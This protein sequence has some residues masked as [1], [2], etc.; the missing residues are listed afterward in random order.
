V[1]INGVGV[2]KAALF[3]VPSYHRPRGRRRREP[4]ASAGRLES[5]PFESVVGYQRGFTRIVKSAMLKP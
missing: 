5:E 1:K 2:A 3:K 4:L